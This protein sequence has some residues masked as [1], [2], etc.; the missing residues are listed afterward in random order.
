MYERTNAVLQV[1][2]H[3]SLSELE[4]GVTVGRSGGFVSRDVVL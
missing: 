1:S 4:D 2:P 3:S